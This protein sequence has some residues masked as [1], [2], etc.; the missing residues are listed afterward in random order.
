MLELLF[1]WALYALSIMLI[2]VVIPGVT[3]KDFPSALLVTVV[4]ALVNA[5]VK[6]A[7][8]FVSLPINFLTLGLFTFVINALLLLLVGK[9]TPNFE[10]SGFLPAF[11]G[12]IILSLL[13]IL[14]GKI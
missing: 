11:I 3:V 6:P 5:V 12:A 2:V 10:V 9:I 7:L 8:M 4:L 1:R 14:I 13:S